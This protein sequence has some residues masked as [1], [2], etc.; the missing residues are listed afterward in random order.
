MTC[1]DISSQSRPAW[2]P[3]DT[4]TLASHY[5]A[6]ISLELAADAKYGL[7]LYDA[8]RLCR[9]RFLVSVAGLF[10][11]YEV[12]HCRDMAVCLAC[13]SVVWCRPSRTW[14]GTTELLYASLMSILDRIAYCEK[15]WPVYC[16]ALADIVIGD[17]CP[18]IGT[19]Q[20]PWSPM[21]APSTSCAPSLYDI[22][23]Q[24][25]G[26]VKRIDMFISWAFRSP[27]WLLK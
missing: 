14:G 15:Y 7:N 12:S 18:L 4:V 1:G 13:L 8:I 17:S 20:H 24:L 16:A 25:N 3:W 22:W 6:V 23:R 21:P 9:V 5:E 2:L 10:C 27:D 26:T 11:L 19:W